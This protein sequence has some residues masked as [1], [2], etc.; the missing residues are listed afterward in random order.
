MSRPTADPR[1]PSKAWGQH[2]S[3]AEHQSTAPQRRPEDALH[4]PMAELDSA[5][6]PRGGAG[7]ASADGG[8]G[9][10]RELRAPAPSFNHGALQQPTWSPFGGSAPAFASG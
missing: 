6:T 5:A 1:R 10:R 4:D 3:G 9:R 2:G 7:V 8:Y